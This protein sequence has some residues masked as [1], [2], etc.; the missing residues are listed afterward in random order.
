MQTRVNYVFFFLNQ[1][2]QTF[3]GNGRQN[4]VLQGSWIVRMYDSF[5]FLLF[6]VVIIF[7]FVDDTLITYKM[8]DFARG[9]IIG[10]MEYGPSHSGVAEAVIIEHSPVVADHLRITTP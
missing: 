7:I 8:E 9:R 5:Y 6:L 10:M 3:Q 2:N 4:R 1:S